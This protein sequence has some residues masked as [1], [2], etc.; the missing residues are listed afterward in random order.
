MDTTK[1]DKGLYIVII[2]LLVVNIATLGFLWYSSLRPGRGPGKEPMRDRPR[3]E[4]LFQEELKFSPEQMKKI[5]AMREENF[6]ATDKIH[7]ELKGLQKS[8]MEV[9]RTGNDEEAKRISGLTG[10]KMKELE[11]LR[12]GHFKQIRDMC[13]ETQK[14]KLDEMTKKIPGPENFQP[15]DMNRPPELNRRPDMSYPPDTSRK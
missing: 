5:E 13:D 14:Q 1:K 8:M 10:E 11:M 4:A 9:V 12:Y 15:P 6:K 3:P 2:A 7:D